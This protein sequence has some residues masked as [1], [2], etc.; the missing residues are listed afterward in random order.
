MGTLPLSDDQPRHR[1][2]IGVDLTN[3]MLLWTPDRSPWRE[4]PQRG[5]IVLV[6]WPPA[7][8]T[9][10]LIPMSWGAC[11]ADVSRG[12]FAERRLQLASVLLQLMLRDKLAAG[13][14][15]RACWV[16]DEYR[17]LLSEDV[18]VPPWQPRQSI[19]G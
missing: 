17:D 5:Q 15:H 7:V 13:A 10:P 6:A 2:K 3:T 12:N 19:G 16:L 4:N 9:N 11:D 1:D 8:R 14:V 18:P